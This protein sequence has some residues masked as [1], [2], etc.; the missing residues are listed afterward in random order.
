MRRNRRIC[1]GFPQPHPFPVSILFY[2]SFFSPPPLFPSPP[3]ALSLTVSLDFQ[4][5]YFFYRGNLWL[6]EG[7]ASMKHGSLRDQ[8]TEKLLT[9]WI[10]FEATYDRFKY[11]KHLFPSSHR[12]RERETEIDRVWEFLRIV[13]ILPVVCNYNRIAAN[14]SKN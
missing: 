10:R 9:S 1:A 8:G 13:N 6:W 3:S 12:E 2:L 5:Y 7:V 4:F 14:R 11:A